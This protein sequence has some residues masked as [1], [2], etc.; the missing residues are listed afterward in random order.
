M[1]KD[2]RLTTLHTAVAVA[3]IGLS[4]AVRADPIEDLKAQIDSLSKKVTGLEQKAADT[5]K[6]A[7]AGANVVT[8]GAT[9]GSFKLPGSDT[10]VTLG[11]YVKLDAIFSDRSA[12]VGSTADQEY[13][14]AGVPVGPTAGANERNQVK[15][16]ARQSRFNI[17]T[18]TPTG[19]G[20]LTTFVE[21][22]LFGV[23]GNESVSN[24]NGLRVRH[25]YGTLGHLLAGQTWTT[26]SDVDTYAETVDFGGPAGVIFARQAQVR[27]TQPFAGGQWAIALENPETVVS[28]PS[29]DAFRADDDRFPDIAGKI[30][31]D[32]SWGKYSVAALARQ[33]RV[34]SASA[35]AS[36]EQK[37][38]GALGLNGVIPLLARD[39]L[40][41]SAS[42]GNAIG[43]YSV[44]FFTDGILDSD[45]HLVLPRQWLAMAAYRHFWN[46]NLR[47]TIALS[48][49]RS[50]NPP[51]TAGSVNRA[52]ES[53]HV[54]VIWSPLAQVNIGLEYIHATR[55]IENGQ[56]GRLNRIQTSAQYQF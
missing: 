46:A 53:A 36:R 12:G 6:P 14:A 19:L 34:D 11:G 8:G 16:H 23:S 2:R 39:D 29:G 27:W 30:K 37:W 48:G 7:A 49:L 18:S 26:F 41:L 56:T 28:L 24:S 50:N 51:G 43:R 32:T 17:K 54:N 1:T 10:S 33:I 13:E 9:K 55:T 3:T 44:G 52:A 4:A 5:M 45:S 42:Y 22:D 25:A 47:S 35:P 20:D 38:G 15:L 31:F 40:R 21:F